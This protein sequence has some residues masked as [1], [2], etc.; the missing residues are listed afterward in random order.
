V[1][2]LAGV[3]SVLKQEN[4]SLV[5]GHTAEGAE[6]SVGLAVTGLLS[7]VHDGF[8]KGPL[9]PQSS[10]IITKAVGTGTVLAADMRVEAK[11]D[12]VTA[13]YNSMLLSNSPAAKVLSNYNCHACTDVTGF[14]LLGHLIEMIQYLEEI[15]D[16]SS[17]TEFLAVDLFLNSVP[18][19]PGAIDCVKKGILSSLHPQVSHLP[20]IL[21]ILI[22]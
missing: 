2:L 15:D 18:T 3:L 13:A 1:Q 14:G 17:A 21:F 9:R 10:I 19:L 8:P 16:D 6:L 20:L 7:S 22:D 4:C 5:G 12:W 11:G